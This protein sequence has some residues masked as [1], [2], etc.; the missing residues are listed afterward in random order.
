MSL[1]NPPD[2]YADPRNSGPGESD[3]EIHALAL[4][5]ADAA[6]AAEVDN[7]AAGR[8]DQR[9]YAGEQWPDNA[10]L[11]RDQEGRPVLTINRLPSFGRQIT[12]DIR[13]DTPAIRVLPQKDATQEKAD[14]FTGLIRSIEQR[15][16]AK[17]AYVQAVDNAMQT[18]HGAFRILTEYADDDV[19]EQ[20][21]RIKRIQDPFG[22]LF[23]PTATEPT[24]EDGAYAFVFDD[25]AIE[26][27][28]KEYPKARLDGFPT[29][30]AQ[31]ALVW[32][33]EKTIRVAEYWYK[34]P[35]TR[36]LQL[37][38]D[39]TTRFADELPEGTDAKP[40]PIGDETQSLGP[41]PQEAPQEQHLE[42]EPQSEAVQVVN[43]RRV[44]T[45]EI[46]QC[47]INGAEVL[48]KPQR[49]AGKYIPIV[50]VLGEEIRMDGRTIR[51]G[52]VRDA[53][54]PQQVLNYAITAQTEAAGMAPKAPFVGT[55]KQFE[56][57]EH[58]WAQAGAK[59]NAY[60][61]YNADP[62]APGAPQR[63]APVPTQP[64]LGEL[65][66]QAS[67]HLK[68]ITGI[69][70]A[71]LGAP[72]NEK[73][74]K[75][76]LARQREGD[77]STFYF[78][79]NLA[80]AIAYAGRILIDLIPKIYDT[81]RV[82][83][84]LKEDGT[85]DMVEI[86]KPMPPQ[87]QLIKDRQML[88]AIK[89]DLN[90]ITV[91]KYDV[92]VS[93]GPG[94]ATKRAEAANSISQLVQGFP[95]VMQVAGDLL[96]KSMD[97]PY[98]EEIAARL[99]RMIPPQIR[100]DMPQPGTPGGPPPPPPPP[101]VIADMQKSMAQAE[102]YKAQAEQ[103]ASVAAVNM[104]KVDETRIANIEAMLQALLNGATGQALG[105]PQQPAPP[106]PQQMQAMAHAQQRHE[107]AMAHGH[108]KMA[109]QH[110]QAAHG[111]AV[112]AANQAHAAHMAELE[113]VNPPDNNT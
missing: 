83:R 82:V 12:G 38:S 2:S 29:P 92:T 45:V 61:P 86:N 44:Q 99:E 9:F 85:G 19:F 88:D 108:Q 55:V 98:A 81:Q 23:D 56:G 28:E 14:I 34:K 39:G 57:Y 84:I 31:G 64:G 51:K 96:I 71:S 100:E 79:D 106:D 33:T 107:Q 63:V 111:M 70:D 102:L 90:D 27:F 8:E 15:S 46:W 75:A 42:G 74:G 53:R 41:E 62:N 35:V 36:T 109:M 97:I 24:K 30:P 7:I 94:Y 49:W 66:M 22:A 18:G 112:D 47:I 59:N 110:A 101:N 58:V 91:G 5:R 78:V 93:T 77:T 10:K 11:A 37:L 60:L 54:D 6:W 20:E 68:E 69:F 105:V 87:A 113:P 26:A 1:R 76:I 89:A 32:K 21:I 65:V 16:F 48:R 104:S 72:S 80:T 25:M 17:A 40:K 103:A 4:E 3:A 73:S 13:K 67:Q 52:L 43:E 50:P 95:Q